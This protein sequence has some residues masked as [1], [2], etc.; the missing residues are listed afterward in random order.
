MGKVKLRK[1]IPVIQVGSTIQQNF[2]ENITKHGYG[3]YDVNTDQYDFVNLP[4]PKP[5]LKFQI[6]SIDDLVDGTE[7]LLNG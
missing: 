6:K 7:K 1:K 4:N 3:V 5:F 2:G